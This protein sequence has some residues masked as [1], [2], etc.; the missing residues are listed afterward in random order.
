MKTYLITYDLFNPQKNLSDLAYAIALIAVSEIHVMPHVRQITTSLTA[1]DI[2]AHLSA[3]L[4]EGDRLI[5]TEMGASEAF[6]PNQF[7]IAAQQGPCSR[8]DS[9][10]HSA[11]P[12]A[13]ELTC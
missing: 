5:V 12:V 3:V 4:T 8:P 2:A 10:A 6:M 7:A 11:S 13:A 9:L 1:S